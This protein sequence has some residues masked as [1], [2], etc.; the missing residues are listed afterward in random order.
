MDNSITAVKYLHFVVLASLVLVDGCVRGKVGGNAENSSNVPPYINISSKQV[1]L[2]QDNQVVNAIN[3]KRD[4]LQVC[5]KAEGQNEN[6]GLLA[7]NISRQICSTICSADARIVNKGKF[8]LQILIHSKEETVDKDGDYILMQARIDIE[9]MSADGQRI[10]GTK[11][12]EIANPHRFLGRNLAC[13]NLE[14]SAVE[15]ATDWCRQELHRIAEMEIDTAIL[16]IELPA[17]NDESR[18]YAT[19]ATRIR[20]IGNVLESM[21]NI[22]SFE[23]ID[24]NSSTGTCQY[25]VAYFHSAYPNGISNEVTTL[26]NTIK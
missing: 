26:V 12:L 18:D 21:H 1:N 19:D 9:I 15:K 25:R 22:V 20:S 23:F 16:M 6:D 10:F 11:T 4:L 5:F 2:L 7:S 24:Y 13:S 3:V 8:D 17:S 14:T